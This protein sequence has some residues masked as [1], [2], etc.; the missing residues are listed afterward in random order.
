[1]W[2]G[3]APV[4]QFAA[5]VK[6]EYPS[7]PALALTLHGTEQKKEF[8]HRNK[9]RQQW[10]AQHSVTEGFELCSKIDNE[11]RNWGKVTG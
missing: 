3:K 5:H 6:A 11:K 8:I 4:L 9:F 10:L 1:M 7:N 2:S